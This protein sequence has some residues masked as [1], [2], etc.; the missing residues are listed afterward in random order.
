MG[1]DTDFFQ[2]TIVVGMAV[3]CTLGDRTFNVMVCLIAVHRVLRLLA[4]VP[5][6]HLWLFERGT[7]IFRVPLIMPPNKQ[8]TRISF[9]QFFSYW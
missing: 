7:R 5:S 2:G 8:N 4:C 3:V 9:W 1:A 6:K